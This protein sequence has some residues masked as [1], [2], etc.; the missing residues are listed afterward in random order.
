MLQ[1]LFKVFMLD[2]NI[3]FLKSKTDFL[4]KKNA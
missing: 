1:K 4:L 3:T 2:E